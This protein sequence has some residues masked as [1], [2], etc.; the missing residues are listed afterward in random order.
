VN[1]RQPL[2]SLG[3]W[4]Q[5]E[6]A[7]AAEN[8][9]VVRR[10]LVEAGCSKSEMQSILWSLHAP[11]TET[12]VESTSDKIIGRGG[13]ILIGAVCLGGVFAWYASGF[14]DLTSKYRYRRERAMADNRPWPQVVLPAFAC[15]A[16]IGGSV[17]ATY[18]FGNVRKRDGAGAPRD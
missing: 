9:P 18:V 14:G 17:A 11:G 2:E 6:D 10:L 8:W 12:K 4:H 13:T 1:I 7:V 3:K 5:Y 15:G 16:L